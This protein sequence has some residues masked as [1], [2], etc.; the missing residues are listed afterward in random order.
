MFK[1]TLY[2]FFG[3]L[4]AIGSGSVSIYPIYSFYIKNKYN[5]SLREIN[6]YGSFINIGSWISFGMGIIYDTLGP[7]ISNFF[8]FFLLPV[9]LMIL[10]RLI[11][12]YYNV[13]L[14]W[15][16]FM[17]FIMGQGSALLY[18]SSLTTSL[19]NFSKK[20][21]S[22]L[23]GLIVSNCAISPSVFASIKEALDT[24][25][26]PEFIAYVVFHI[27]LIVLLSFCFFDVVKETEPN[28]FKEKIFRANKQTFIVDLFCTANFYGIMIFIILLVINHIFSIML[29]AFLIFPILHIILLVFVIMEKCHQFDDLLESK[30]DASHGNFNNYDFNNT[31]DVSIEQNNENN[32][33]EEEEKENDYEGQK[34]SL[35]NKNN[36]N[37]M[38]NPKDNERSYTERKNIGKIMNKLELEGLFS[39]T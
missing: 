36:L 26:I 39:R 3:I 1:R 25:T 24:F 18:T 37:N 5:F 31:R 2:L 7:I 22:K 13:S 20:N 11:E 10:Y 16:L 6:L 14:F 8:G 12:S 21:S 34:N 28:S 15:F 19:K 30:Y 23:V 9:C 38:E 35:E 33:N 27:S 29:P 32:I 4:L 17:A